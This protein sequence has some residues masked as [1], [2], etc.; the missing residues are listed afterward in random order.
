MVTSSVSALV[1]APAAT[2]SAVSPWL[3]ALM[4]IVLATSSSLATASCRPLTSAAPNVP[5]PQ[6]AS[7]EQMLMA[8]IAIEKYVEKAEDYASCARNGSDRRAERTLRRAGRLAKRYND[9]SKIYLAKRADS[10]EYARIQAFLS[11][12]R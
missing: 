2:A 12:K 1:P 6:T 8:R 4:A 3:L 5:D 10:P 11:S 9:A 7:Y